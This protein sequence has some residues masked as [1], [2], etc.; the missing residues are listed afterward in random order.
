MADFT[1]NLRLTEL[2]TGEGSGTW[3]DTTNLNLKAI[4]DGLGYNTAAITGD[5]T[6]TIPDGRN[7]TATDNDKARSM[8]FALTSSGSLSGTKVIT[9]APNTISRVMLIENA[10]T[11]T[12]IT[13][14]K[15]G[16]GGTVDIPNG[17]TKLVYM[18]GAGAG[19]K[20]IDISATLDLTGVNING[21]S[22][23]T[24]TSL[25]ING[26]A[27]ISGDLTLSAG[28]DGALNFSTASSIKILDDSAT[29]LVIEEADNAYMT[30]VTTNSG[31]KVAFAKPIE[32]TGAVTADALTMGDSEKITLGTGGD[33]EIYHD[34]SNSHILDKGTGS[35]SIDSAHFAIRSGATDDADTTPTEHIRMVITA[36]A[37]GTTGFSAGT[38]SSGSLSTG[39]TNPRLEILPI[40]GSNAGQVTVRGKLL[41]A[42]DPVDSTK[43]GSADLGV[44]GDI[45]AVNLDISGNFDI[46]GEINPTGGSA[47]TVNHGATFVRTSGDTT[48]LTVKNTGTPSES[49]TCFASIE[50]GGN[51]GSFIDLKK[52]NGDDYDLRIEHGVNANNES[53]ITSK[54]P[55]I[56]QTQASGGE[57]TIKREG[58]TKLATSSAGIDV[59]GT[60]TASSDIEVTDKTKGIILASPNGSRF[61]LEVANDGTLSTEAL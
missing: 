58:S 42:Q 61:R 48:A 40:S 32:V 41:V 17:K 14:I 37:S 51:G 8:Y 9:F 39:M 45:T 46:D 15:Q 35:L 23:I 43:T 47:L 19:G 29:A 34:G 60:I 59:T 57:V 10:T 31:E 21:G 16:S 52:P 25:D 5:T 12:A 33:L 53:L 54:H 27:D 4:A 50:V 13:Q 44:I 18:D 28:G 26:N 20:V 7:S 30:F 3:G 55:L 11:G 2:A 38:E 1:N 49:F 24:G 6:F 22:S 56:I 36:G